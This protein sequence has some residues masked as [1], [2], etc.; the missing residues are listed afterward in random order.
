VRYLED[1]APGQE[2][3]LGSKTVTAEEIVEYARDYDPQPF[4]LDEDAAARTPFGGLVAS[5]WQTGAIAMRLIVDHLLKD[6]ASLGSPGLDRV[7]WLAPVRPGDTLSLK[8]IVLQVTPSRSKPDRGVVM[9]RYEMRNQRGE[10]V[11]AVEG[12]GMFGARPRGF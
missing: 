5:G 6:C 8:G 9:S 12:A 3:A 4:H 1:F 7:Q 11:Y 10:L 2:F